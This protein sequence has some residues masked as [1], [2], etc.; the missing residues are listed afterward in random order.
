MVKRISGDRH[1]GFEACD[2]F[3]PVRHVATVLTAPAFQQMRQQYKKSAG[4]RDRCKKLIAHGIVLPFRKPTQA[5]NGAGCRFRFGMKAILKIA[6]GRFI[7]MMLFK[8]FNH[9]SKLTQC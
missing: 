1:R 4:P 9:I 6:D 8:D 7:H 5:M 2:C 3:H